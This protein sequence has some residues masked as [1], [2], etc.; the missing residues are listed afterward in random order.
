M[1][2][3]RIGIIGNSLS[4]DLAAS[5]LK[6]EY[7]VLRFTDQSDCLPAYPFFGND[8]KTGIMK[9]FF[10]DTVEE[11]PKIRKNAVQ[12]SIVLDKEEYLY[13]MNIQNFQKKLEIDFPEDAEGINCFFSEIERI[14]IEWSEFIMNRFDGTKVK[15][16]ASAK[17]YNINV[18]EVIENIG[19]Q[20]HSFIRIIK[21]IIPVKEVAFSVF[22]GYLYTQF[23]DI[24]AVPF[25][26]LAYCHSVGK[27]ASE[28][29]IVRDISELNV[30][31]L[32]SD[33]EG[34]DEEKLHAVVDLRQS[35]KSSE[36]SIKVGTLSPRIA[37]ASDTLY[38]INQG[39]QIITKVWN[40]HILN[41]NS[42]FQWCFEAV[43]YNQE[44][45]SMSQVEKCLTRFM[46]RFRETEVLDNTRLNQR[47]DL[48]NG[49][50]YAWAFSKK[51]SLKD[52][53]NLIRKH[54][55]TDFSCTHWGFAWFSA[56][57][58]ILNV[59]NNQM[60]FTYDR[61]KISELR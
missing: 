37:L 36:N 58:H 28:Q 13:E 54:T 6:N 57:Y 60:K 50:G 44:V 32:S 21:T 34:L 18:E 51:E 59:V 39:D 42:Q 14:G 41:Y 3:K 22:A 25:D 43:S 8:L 33:T 12:L 53:T 29:K 55:L 4:G 19:I 52:P 38:L 35:T 30:E 15:F 46:T 20:S 56:A 23:F 11:M 2:K 40:S 49:A 9:Q 47:F 7:T 31:K 24:C 16:S 45:I 5:L 61:Y 1:N 26:A 17:Y 48:V 27:K 10:E